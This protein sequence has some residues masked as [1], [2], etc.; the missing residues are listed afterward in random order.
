MRHVQS[1]WQPAPPSAPAGRPRGCLATLGV[2]LLMLGIVGGGF[3][4]ASAVEDLPMPPVEVGQ[5]VV[6]DPL[7]GWEFGGR[8]EDGST[9]L[10]SRGDGSMAIGLVA[11]TVTPEVAARD[12]L[13]EWTADPEIHITYGPTQDVELR[14]GLVGSRFHYAGTFAGLA[15][16]VEGEV[17]ALRGSEAT[18]VADAWAGDGDFDFVRAEVDRMIREA[19]L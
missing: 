17:T 10:L 2:L 14:P 12:L 5:G 6:I 15:S 16:P 13:Q 4:A 18:I 8:S 1:G 7:P 11:G 19:T 3:V 9:V